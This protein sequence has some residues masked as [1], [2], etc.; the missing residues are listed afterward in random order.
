MTKPEVYL[1]DGVYAT[2]DGFGIMLDLRA[3]DASKI[4]LEPQVFDALVRF[5]AAIKAPPSADEYDIKR[6]DDATHADEVDRMAD[7]IDR[8]YEAARD[9]GELPHDDDENPIQHQKPEHDEHG[10][11]SDEE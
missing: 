2:F 7:E 3:Q 10:V 8:A 9:R 6:D 11:R 5:Q 4:F 1:G